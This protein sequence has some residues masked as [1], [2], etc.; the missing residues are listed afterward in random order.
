MRALI[1]RVNWANV[2]VAGSEVGSIDTGLLVFL[3]IRQGD[4]EKDSQFLAQKIATLRVFEDESGKM[5]W[6]L[7]QIGGSV[8]VVSQFTLHADTKKG[9]RPAFTASEKPEHAKALYEYFC[10]CLKKIGLK[11]EQGQFAAQMMVSLQNDGPV[12]ILLQSENN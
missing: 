6:D 9:R 8:L 12:T 1:Q 7:K 5:N 11:V 4:Q 2:V 10:S 3:G